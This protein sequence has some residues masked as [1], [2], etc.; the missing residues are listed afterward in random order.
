VGPVALILL[1]VAVALVIVAEWPRLHERLGLDAREERRREKRKSQFRVIAG[2][3]E[4]D[5][6]ELDLDVPSEP[7]ELE[8]DFAASVQRDL[9][10]LPVMD[11]HEDRS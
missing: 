11:P 4:R 9:E 2:S 8:D 1:V 5:H 3:G 6:E 7:P 10:N